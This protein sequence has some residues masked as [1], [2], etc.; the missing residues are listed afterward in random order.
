MP[1]QRGLSRHWRRSS[2]TVGRVLV[3]LM[4]RL[5]RWWALAEQLVG[6]QRQEF[7]EGLALAHLLEQARRG[8]EH[9]ALDARRADLLVDA[10]ELGHHQAVEA[11]DGDRLAVRGARTVARPLPQLRAADLRRGRVLHEVI[12]RHAAVAAQPGL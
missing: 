10:V 11:L 3:T 5:I 6:R 9:A 7:I 2:S 1:R 8:R 12:E 4:G